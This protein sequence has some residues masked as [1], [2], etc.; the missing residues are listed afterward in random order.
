MLETKS[1]LIKIIHIPHSVINWLMPASSDS[2]SW[3]SYHRLDSIY[4]WIDRYVISIIMV[5]REGLN[6][7]ILRLYCFTDII[8][9]VFVSACHLATPTE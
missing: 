2:M 3:N 7:T 9:F 6:T 8:T 1:E 5:D 4:S